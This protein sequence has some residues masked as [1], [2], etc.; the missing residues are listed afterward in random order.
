MVEEL[1]VNLEKAQEDLTELEQVSKPLK[2][3]REK[4][5]LNITLLQETFQKIESAILEA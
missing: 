2:T 3:E 5:C 4:T 1:R